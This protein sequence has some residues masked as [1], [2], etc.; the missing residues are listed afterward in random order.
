[1]GDAEWARAIK[2][3]MSLSPPGDVVLE[4]LVMLGAVVLIAVGI[5]TAL[6]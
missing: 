5:F 1:M 3:T 2:A 6:L 4:K